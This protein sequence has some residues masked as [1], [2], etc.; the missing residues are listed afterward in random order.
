MGSL[1]FERDAH[2]L[3]NLRI[4]SKLYKRIWIN[5]WHFRIQLQMYFNA[6]VCCRSTWLEKEMYFVCKCRHFFCV[7]K[8]F[9]VMKDMSAKPLLEGFSTSDLHWLLL[10]TFFHRSIVI[11]Y[12][13]EG[14]HEDQHLRIILKQKNCIRLHALMKLFKHSS[15]MCC[16]WAWT[17]FVIS[18]RF[19][20]LAVLKSILLSLASGVWFVARKVFVSAVHRAM[21]LKVSESGLV[22]HLFCLSVG[23]T[24]LLFPSVPHKPCK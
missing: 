9:S 24:H 22:G 12:F 23:D 11:K 3:F 1:T 10:K 5:L 7:A 14:V 17:Y 8:V 18:Y 21:N 2:N 13:D 16:L 6:F 15:D 4:Y 20:N 19:L